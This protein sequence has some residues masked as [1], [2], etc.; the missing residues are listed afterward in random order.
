MYTAPHIVLPQIPNLHRIDTYLANGGYAAYRKALSMTP[1]QVIDEVKRSGL[2]GR[3]GACFPTGL[4][5]SFMPKGNDKPKYLAINGDESEPGSFKD[6]QIFESNPH[7]LIEGILIAGYAMG[8]KQAFIYIRGEYH[9]WVNMMEDA[10]R[11]AYDKGY[12]GERM[13]QTFGGDYTIDIVVHKGAGAY[14]CGEETSLMNSLEG[15]R[16]Y[17][18]FKPPFPANKGLWGMPTTINN[19]ET[20]ATVP[21]ILSMG[22]DAYSKIGAPGHAGTILY[23]VSGHVN[24]PGVYELPTG[25]LLT[26][27]IQNVCGGVPGNKKVK[28]VIPGGSSMPPLR[29]DEIEGVRMDEESLKVLGTHIGTAGIM[30]MDEDTD[31]VKVTLR[32]ARFY[33]HESCGQCTPCREG[34]GWME[35]VLHRIEHGDATSS[36]ID[37]LLNV[38]SNIEGNTICALG[39]AAAWPVRGFILKFREEFEARCKPQRNYISLNVVHGRRATADTLTRSY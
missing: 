39:D 8:V 36:D 25:A 29:G 3:G 35:K 7:Q 38:A 14:I 4:K 19:V 28:A 31:I 15:D 23:G 9:K 27:I 33:H 26:D 16:A 10:V 30:V 34:C 24:K 18:R 32:I 21:A 17:P 1:D 22:A 6:R 2:R 12:V 5:W 37:L 13:K 20:I 11:E